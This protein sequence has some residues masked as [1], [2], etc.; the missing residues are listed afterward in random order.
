MSKTLTVRV[1]KSLAHWLQQKAARSGMSQGQIVRDQLERGRR[2]DKQTKKFMRFAGVIKGG[3]P[4]L[5][6]RKG[7][8][9]G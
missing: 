4:D 3:P 1:Q 9:K 5:S 8:S 7:Y 6:T 2:G